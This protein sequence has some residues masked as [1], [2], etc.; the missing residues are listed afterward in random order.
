[1]TSRRLGD[2]A[3]RLIVIDVS[4]SMG[5]A[6]QAQG[7]IDLIESFANGPDQAIALIDTE[8]RRI[9]KLG[10]VRDALLRIPRG[11]TRLRPLIDVLLDK[12]PVLLLIT[13]KDGYSELRGLGQVHLEQALLGDTVVEVV[14]I[15]AAPTSSTGTVIP[16]LYSKR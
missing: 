11:T 12:H 5:N 15:S 1:M 14:E 9:C 6:A 10:E 16:R 7:L 2:A 8:I 13:D 4:S 3:D